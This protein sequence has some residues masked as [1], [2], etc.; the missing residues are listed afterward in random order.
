MSFC[1]H[2]HKHG[3]NI[4]YHTNFCSNLTI[5]QFYHKIY[6]TFLP[7]ILPQ[8]LPQTT[9]TN[10]PA[11]RR[12]SGLGSDLVMWD[13][14]EK[15]TTSKH[16]LRADSTYTWRAKLTTLGMETFR[17][18]RNT[19]WQANMLARSSIMGEFVKKVRKSGYNQSTC[20][21]VVVSGL[22]HYYRKLWVNL[23]GAP[24]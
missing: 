8:I 3:V 21:G 23:E 9:T 4:Y 15:S 18:M 2:Y 19:T 24:D 13:L 1:H 20:A 7:H 16:V 5:F 11:R 6:H 14:Y 10:T 17:R 22:R 12:R